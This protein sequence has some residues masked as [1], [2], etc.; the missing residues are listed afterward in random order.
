MTA[1]GVRRTGAV[2]IEFGVLGPLTV[3]RENRPIAIPTTMLQRLLTL[4]LCCAARPIRADAVADALWS[5]APPRTARKT[6]QVYVHRLRRALGDDGRVVFGPT[7]YQLTVASDEMDVYA[8]D[9]LVSDASAA[10][11]Q[12]NLVAARA[13]LQRALA[14]WRGP[15]YVDARD[16]PGVMAEAN[17]LEERRLTAL[18]E[19]IRIDLDLGTHRDVIGEL[20]A[21]IAEHPYRERL[22]AL[23]MLALYR[24]GRQVDALQVYRETRDLLVAELGVEPMTDLQRLHQ[25]MLA[26]DPA[27]ALWSTVDGHAVAWHLPAP[28]ADF[29]GRGTELDRITAHLNGCLD[30]GS[31]PIVAI[32]GLPGIGKTTLAIAAARQLRQRFPCGQ[33]YVDLHGHGEPRDPVQVLRRFLRTMGVPA[34]EI[35]ADVEEAADLYRSRLSHEP[36]LVLL[37]NA[38]SVAQ[39]ASLL[40]PPECAVLVT[41][42]R[43]LTDL[44]GACFVPLEPL[45]EA[46]AV[47]LL[48]RAA[49]RHRLGRDKPAAI[50]IVHACGRLPLAVRIVGAR[51]LEGGTTLVR[52]ADQLTVGARVLD[53]L[54]SAERSVRASLQSA[55]DTLDESERRL[56]RSLAAVTEDDFPAWV[57]DAVAGP[58]IL[59]RLVRASLV[60]PL[61]TDPVGQQRYR[62]HDVVRHFA[63]EQ[64][65]GL[66]RAAERTAVVARIA[67]RWNTLA[68][69]VD[70]VINQLTSPAAAVST[71]RAP[72]PTQAHLANGDKWFAVELPSIVYTARLA[73]ELGLHA[74][75][76]A[77]VW[78]CETALRR[79]ARTGD[80]ISL[81]HLG[82]DAARRASDPLGVACL[83]LLLASSYDL[84]ADTT[85]A[86]HF[87]NQAVAGADAVGHTWLRAEARGVL[88]SIYGHRGRTAERAAALGEAIDLYLEV[89]EA[90]QAGVKL[91]LLG[92]LTARAG[93]AE[94]AAVAYE[95]GV[96]LLRADG[97]PVHL[98]HGLRR[99]AVLRSES[100]EPEA[101]VA[102]YRECLA[103][104]HDTGE[105]VGELCVH[106]ELALALL[107][108]GDLCQ[109]MAHAERAA[110]LSERVAGSPLYVAYAKMGRGIVLCH[111]GRS[112]EARAHLL[113]AAPAL[114]TMPAAQATAFIALSRI[115]RQAGEDAAADE[116]GREAE[117]IAE[118]IG[119]VR[120]AE[121]ARATAGQA[122][123]TAD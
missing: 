84:A 36:R 113:G 8:F 121:R 37:D 88:A 11:A 91:T 18:E 22:R 86:E 32:S 35:P 4:L 17:R 24:A 116:A 117:R 3:R 58:A 57:S 45:S 70:T 122:L 20:A 79:E 67:D 46:D 99:L 109:A 25:Q 48:A 12:G 13:L 31:A 66:D 16:I 6:L 76:W 69:E 33:L 123:V 92:E 39:I 38:A 27:L 102:L 21:L 55:Y 56:L 61:G 93:D 49:G 63:A 85:S 82:L 65:A 26:N 111:L 52:L 83:A 114:A 77:L 75:C 9:G 71:A 44:D 43:M 19:R 87:G 97:A 15:A 119:A 7:G 41:G 118:R 5:G 50:S 74:Q 103:L 14:L 89:G 104:L 115:H 64:S 100:G 96:A 30:S 59:G 106:T 101:A 62:L 110:V 34:A 72:A 81:G 47:E 40:P 107:D 90:N 54:T 10:R 68:E 51:S 108:L 53:H 94:T 2:V 120:L 98:A 1:R 95:R 80:L 112:A 60:E 29:V 42:R 78:N 23:Y 73:A 28:L 105:P